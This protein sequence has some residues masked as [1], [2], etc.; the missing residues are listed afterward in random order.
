MIEYDALGLAKMVRDGE[1]KSSELIEITI[2]RIESVNPKLN[3]IIH[4]MYDEAR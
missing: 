3:A 1:I 4:K 2:E